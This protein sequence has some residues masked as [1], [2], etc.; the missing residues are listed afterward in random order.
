MMISLVEPSRL[1]EPSAT[2][3]ATVDRNR[4]SLRRS[5]VRWRELQSSTAA[6]Y[7]V[8]RLIRTLMNARADLL[9]MDGEIQRLRD[10]VQMLIERSRSQAETIDALRAERFM[11]QVNSGHYS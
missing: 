5:I 7:S 2:P 1:R 9:Q 11:N 10:E 3:S 4:R 8:A 6:R